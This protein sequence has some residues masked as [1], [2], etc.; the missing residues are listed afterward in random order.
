MATI[1][2]H[3]AN[4]TAKPSRSAKDQEDLFAVRPL[5]R[6]R[7]WR[8]NSKVSFWCGGRSAAKTCTE[9]K[10]VTRMR[11]ESIFNVGPV[12]RLVRLVPIDSHLET[13]LPRGAFLP[14]KRTKL[15]VVHPV[16]SIVKKPVSHV[17]NLILRVQVKAFADFACN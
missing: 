9:I 6:W 17:H 3:F 5:K 15:R 1:R 11:S 13:F 10:C 14:T 16:P 8:L 12:A 7:D 2:Q 4:F